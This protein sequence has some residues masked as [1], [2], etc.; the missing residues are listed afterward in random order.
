MSVTRNPF[1]Q[2][3]GGANLPGDVR[4]S[5]TADANK[6]ASDGWAASPAAVASA[7]PEM[8]Y[9][10]YTPGTPIA[11]KS[12]RNFKIPFRNSH[13]SNPKTVL[14]TYSFYE[15]CYGSLHIHEGDRE[16]GVDSAG[17]TV[18]FIPIEIGNA[19]GN[20]FIHWLAIW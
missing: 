4:V 16:H 13:K 9:G 19:Q 18:T 11:D 17:F 14:I 2:L 10:C 3:P 7:V 12:I 20:L 15:Y 8:E 6:T 1:Y 5:D